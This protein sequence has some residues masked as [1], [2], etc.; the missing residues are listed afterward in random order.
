MD[1]GRYDGAQCGDPFVSGPLL[2]TNVCGPYISQCALF[3]ALLD[4]IIRKNPSVDK[5]VQPIEPVK[6]PSLFYDFIV[7]GGGNAGAVV[8]GRLS[9]ITKWKVLLIEAGP[10]EPESMYIPSNYAVYAES[11]LDWNYKTTN[12]E[13]ACLLTNGMCKWPRG[14]NLGGT[15]SHHGMAYHRGN[16]KDYER[17][18]QMGN[19][20]WSYD[21]VLPYFK[22]SEDNREIHRVGDKY[23]GTGG[24]LP[25]ERFPWQPPF[26]WDILKAG[27]EM[28]YGVTEDMVGEKIT[29][30]TIA[31]TISDKGV[32]ISSAGS[33]LRPV[34]HR[35]NLHILLNSQVTKV[36]FVGKRAIGVRYIKDGKLHRVFAKR[37]IILSG[38]AIN[39]PHIL[40]LS[41]IGPKN[42]L[43][44]YNIPLVHNLPGVGE[45]L[46]NH[47]SFALN[48]T[49]IDDR[50]LNQAISPTQ[51]Y[52]HNQTGPLSSTGLAQV[53]AVLASKYTTP[54]DPDL[55]I[56][57]AG[58]MANCKNRDT[59]ALRFIQMIPV[60]LHAKSR[61]YL[62]LASSNPLDAPTICS[63]DLQDPQD[64][65][66]ICEGVNVVLSLLEA[67]T[68]KRLKLTLT[69]EPLH[70]CSH[71]EF[72]SYDYWHCAIRYDT[73]T[74]NHQAG[75]CKMGPKSDPMA[76]VD[77]RFRVHG[78]QRLRVIDAASM[79]LMV[80]G[81][82]SAAI[83]M[84]GER[85]S[86]F[87]KEEYN[88]LRNK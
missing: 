53:T 85:G 33:Y 5:F 39:S 88:E 61:G 87:I 38:G 67:P 26:A 37:E 68:M 65:A 18:V 45:N 34:K 9:E 35:R 54:D 82:P 20:G 79:P 43:K 51:M 42:Q 77:S 41:G 28:G 31:Q 29:G 8:A 10:D 75:S 2:N 56:F 47:V 72:K 64:I 30:F 24:V 55:Q 6:Y 16:A 49:L 57:F 25:V 86:D 48:F 12:E 69:S 74:E 84:M 3:L 59:S 46:H 80:S 27:E 11:P 13:N 36:I 1:P 63:Q 83:T 7:V 50:E 66:V 22:K 14:K 60:N 19:E 4:S 70:E 58:Y 15:S 78:L 40:L 23:H 62:R 81:N 21:E 71:H 17:W 73:R 32:R 52:L 44:S 76:V